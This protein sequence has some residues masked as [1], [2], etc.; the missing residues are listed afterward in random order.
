MYSKWI[1]NGFVL[2]MLLISTVSLSTA[3]CPW[4]IK[5]ELYTAQCGVEK[6]VPASAGLLANDPTARAILNP[7]LITIDAK[8]GKL[9]VKADG[10]FIF[11]PSPNIQ[12]GTYVQFKYNA[13]NGACA[14]KFPGIAKIQV[15]CKCRPQVANVNLCLPTTLDEIRKKL[16]AAGVGC[17]GCGDTPTTIDLSKVKLVPGTYSFSIKCPGCQAAFGS[18]TLVSG[19]SASAPS[20]TFCEGTVTLA[21]LK[22]MINA[23]ADCIGTGCD[24]APLI[25]TAKVTIANG[26]VTGG[27]YTATCGAGTNCADT[28]TGTITVIPR[29][30]ASAPSFTFC[31]GTVTLAQLQSMINAQADCIGTGCDQA[32]LINTAKVT[33]ANGFVTGGSYTATCG[34]GTVCADTATGTITVFQKCTVVAPSVTICEGRTLAQ[35]AEAIEAAGPDCT[36]VG[37]DATPVVSFA[38][39]TVVDGLVTGGDYTVTCTVAPNCASSADGAITVVPRCVVDLISLTLGCST[40]ALI[41]AQIKD[42]NSAPCGECDSTPTFQFPVW[43]LRSDGS[44]NVEN[45]AYQYTVTCNAGGLDGCDSS[46]EGEVIIDCQL[47]CPCVATAKDVTVCAGAVTLDQLEKIYLP[48]N[49]SCSSTIGT[50]CDTTAEINTDDVTV[51]AKG[52]VTGG[53]YKAICLPSNG[54]C[55]PVEATGKVTTKTCNTCTSEANAPSFRFCEGTVTKDQLT[56]MIKAEAK[57]TGSGC[58]APKIDLSDV[59]VKDGFV[60]GGSYT[61]TFGEGTVCADTAAGTITVVPRC[62]V[63]LVSITLGCSTPAQIEAQI[64]AENPSPCGDCDTTP[65]FQ[66]PSW[67]LRSD[68]SG[69]VANGAYQY[70]VTCNAGSL[71]GCDSSVAGEVIV[72]CQ[73]PCPCVATAKDV[74]V[75]A[76]MV[77]LDQLEKIYLPGNVSC[78]STIG[79]LCDKTAEINTDDVTVDTNGFVTGGTYKA[80]CLRRMVTAYPSKPRAKLPPKPATHAHAK[81]MLRT[82]AFRGFMLRAN[83]TNTR[84]TK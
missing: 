70:T 57:C 82:S 50:L 49:V 83:T 36:G 71:E 53:T 28:A 3:A 66:F 74:T 31:E 79:T 51:D 10:S 7:N 77:T 55:L 2:A 16:K 29:C 61:V 1:K 52:F 39:V 32:P 9:E 40:P 64:K 20:F 22:G 23:Q 42:E 44:G 60:S 73:L 35:L 43:R 47:P 6:V 81:Q 26:F 27:S 54:D 5:N 76:G 75:C 41:E 65:T 67:R 80:I 38:N 13:T 34:A 14:A 72:D 59:E 45:G 24:Q 4:L 62:V 69:K 12:T 15:S 11:K 33:V 78:R 63:D 56:K 48:G 46:A 25:N 19:C 37:C 30:A 84:W 58:S 21:Q 68:G 8:Y 18:V 17:L